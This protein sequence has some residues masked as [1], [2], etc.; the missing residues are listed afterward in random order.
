[1]ARKSITKRTLAEA[2]EALARCAI[3]PVGIGGIDYYMFEAQQR[4]MD[5]QLAC[6]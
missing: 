5:Q 3:K 6:K 1:M 2:A 4:F